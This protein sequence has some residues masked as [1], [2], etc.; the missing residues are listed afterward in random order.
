VAT[1]TGEVPSIMVSAKAS[2]VA[3]SVAGVKSVKNE[4]TVR[5]A[6]K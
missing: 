5:Q 6:G 1:L 2:E 4:L 3:R